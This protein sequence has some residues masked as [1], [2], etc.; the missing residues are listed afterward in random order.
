MS[1]WLLVILD[2]STE[3]PLFRPVDIFNC[4]IWYTVQKV[5]S[6]A[7][8]IKAVS[9][10]LLSS[11]VCQILWWG[12]FGPLRPNY[13]VLCRV[14]IMNIF[15]FSTWRHPVSLA[16][17]FLKIFLFFSSVYFLIIFKYQVSADVLIYIWVSSIL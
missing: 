2:L 1:K 14:V 6:Y 10:F 17:F 16:P 5:L 3:N 13:W 12:L 4:I 15:V 11:L 7:S 8:S 9:H